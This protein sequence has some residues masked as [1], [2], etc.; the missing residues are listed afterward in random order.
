M[1]F[2]WAGQTLATFHLLMGAPDAARS[3]W[4][5]APASAFSIPFACC[6]HPIA[7]SSSAKQSVALNL[8]GFAQ[9]FES[10]GDAEGNFVCG[11][12]AHP[13]AIVTQSERQFSLT[14]SCK[15]L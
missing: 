9:F 13:R 11:R 7:P 1:R 6:E 4:R 5:P 3:V 12:I 10:K 15:A 2:Y 14:L 8:N